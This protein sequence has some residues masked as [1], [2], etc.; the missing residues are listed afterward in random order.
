MN[1]VKSDKHKTCPMKNKIFKYY[2]KTRLVKKLAQKH[3]WAIYKTKNYSIK[4]C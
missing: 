3:E 2:S 4:N 1:N